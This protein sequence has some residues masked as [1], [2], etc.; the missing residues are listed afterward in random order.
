MHFHHTV[1]RGTSGNAKCTLFA[2]QKCGFRH[3]CAPS[4]RP[5]ISRTPMFS[6]LISRF[7]DFGKVG[8][9]RSRAWTFRVR[10]RAGMRNR[11]HARAKTTLSKKSQ[12]REMGNEFI[13]FREIC[14]RPDGTQKCQKTHFFG[15]KSVSFCI[16][17]SALGGQKCE[18][19]HFLP[20]KSVSFCTFACPRGDWD[21]HE[22][23]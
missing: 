11:A 16:P 15:C 20:P 21:S 10:V 6:C 9:S 1:V 14:G 23:L 17:A 7:C 8:S 2:D 22:T 19:T 13:G 3:F 18:M 4:G 12:D 5:Q